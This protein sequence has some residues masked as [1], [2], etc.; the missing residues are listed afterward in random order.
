MN[1]AIRFSPRLKRPVRT[2]VDSGITRRGNC[3]FRTI[4]SWLT[5]EVHGRDVVASWKKVN[6]TTL[7]SS[8]TG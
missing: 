4:P 3:V 7:N 8:R 5:T 1:T 2:T 6:T